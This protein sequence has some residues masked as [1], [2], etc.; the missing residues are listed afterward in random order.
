MSLWFLQPSRGERS[1][2]LG[3]REHRE[4][5]FGESRAIPPIADDESEEKREKGEKC[6]SC[7]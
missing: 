2:T 5:F 6:T 3:A 4:R 7:C 1:A